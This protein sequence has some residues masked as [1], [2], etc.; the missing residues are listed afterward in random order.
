[1]KQDGKLER[2]W[3]QGD[4][5]DAINVL[6]VAAGHNIRLILNWLR[7]FCA[8]IMALLASRTED[9]DTPNRRTAVA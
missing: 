4:H 2:H 7:I 8:F 9:A 3:L 5:G 6:L 1:M